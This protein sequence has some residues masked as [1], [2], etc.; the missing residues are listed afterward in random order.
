MFEDLPKGS[1]NK[2]PFL[3]NGQIRIFVKGLAHD[4]GQKLESFFRSLLL[5]KIGLK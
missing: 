5:D 1:V 3:H 4:F 2:M